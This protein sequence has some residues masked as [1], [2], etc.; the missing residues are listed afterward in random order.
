MDSTP[1]LLAIIGHLVGDYLLQ[2]DW[3]ALNKKKPGMAGTLPCTI[4]AFLWTMAVTCFSGWYS[5]AVAVPLM[6]AHYA[7]D[8]TGIIMWW[9]TRVI[10]QKTFATGPCAPWSIIVVDNV[11]HIVTLWAAWRFLA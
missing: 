9:M 8:R 10:R 6:L 5:A 1:L 7:Q 4:H 3:M 2:N 11:W